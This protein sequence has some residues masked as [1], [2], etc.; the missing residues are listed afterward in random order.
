MSE[1][2]DCLERHGVQCCETR[3]CLIHIQ[4]V[5][6][7]FGCV[8]FYLTF[9]IIRLVMML[10]TVSRTALSSQPQ[11]TSMIFSHHGPWLVTIILMQKYMGPTYELAK[12]RVQEHSWEG[13]EL[14][15]LSFHYFTLTQTPK[16]ETCWSPKANREWKLDVLHKKVLVSFPQGQSTV[17]LGFHL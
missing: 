13:E 8:S 2:W 4:S 17:L 7:K 9:K 12:F 10:A 1:T 3:M 11:N 14:F 15:K 6:F 5:F 16:K